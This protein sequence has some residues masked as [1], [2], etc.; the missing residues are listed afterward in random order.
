MSLRIPR[1][2]LCVESRTAGVAKYNYTGNFK[3]V[4]YAL[5]LLSRFQNNMKFKYKF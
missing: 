2:R 4:V 5:L 1:Q 3:V